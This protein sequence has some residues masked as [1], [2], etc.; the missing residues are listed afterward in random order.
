MKRIYLPQF[1]SDQI[2][3]EDEEHHYL[4]NVLRAK[5]GMR[6]EIMTSGELLSA[7]IDGI[8]K[9]GI[10]ARIL[11]RRA[12][13]PPAY[14]L[15]VYQSLLKREYMDAVVEKYAELG[16][17]SVIPVIAERSLP[18]LKENALRRYREIAKSAALQSEQEFITEIKEPLPVN[19]ITVVTNA[20]N[21]LFYERAERKSPPVIT[22][23]NV[24]LFIGP[25]GG[26]ADKE[27]DYLLGAGFSAVSP[28][29]SILKAETAAVVFA[30]WVR[31]A[32]ESL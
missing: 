10:S 8:Q 12:L 14:T 30:G 26:F 23:N 4:K 20:D 27:V 19:K 16:V 24:A 32:L 6:I 1:P 17:T 13:R 2:L 9:R 31:I 11:S 21:I 22:R 15:T 5:P 28:V 7:E 3:I 18:E 29:S 25:E